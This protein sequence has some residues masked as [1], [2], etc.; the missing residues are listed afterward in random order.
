MLGAFTGVAV[1]I[2]ERRKRNVLHPLKPLGNNS[3]DH[4]TATDHLFQDADSM[5]MLSEAA[6]S[7][8]PACRAGRPTKVARPIDIN[9]QTADNLQGQMSAQ[10]RSPAVESTSTGRVAAGREVLS[11]REDLQKTT[12]G[13]FSG[14][15]KAVSIISL[16][17]GLWLGLGGRSIDS[18]ASITAVAEAVAP[19]ESAS[20]YKTVAI[21]DIQPA[22]YMVLADNPQTPGQAGGDFG[23]FDA[24]TWQVHRFLMDKPDGGWL[25]IGLARPMTW[26][27]SVERSDSGQVWLEFE[28]LGMAD[29]ATLQKTEPCPTDILGE[30]RLVTGTFEH[31]S[32][33]V[34]NLFITGAATPI[35]CTAGHFFWSEDRK[36]FVQA[37]DLRQGERLRLADGRLTHLEHSETIVEQ[38]PVY[39]LE[40][41]GEHVY[42]VGE[43][44]VLVHNTS[45]PHA[46]TPNRVIGKKEVLDKSGTIRANEA[47]LD[48][49]VGQTPKATWKSNYGELRKAM[50]ERRP[51]RDAT[52]KIKSPFLNAERYILKSRGWIQKTV[53]GDTFWMP[54]ST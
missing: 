5:T 22:G 10:R 11:G 49:V 44:A 54:P 20:K 3:D 40:V 53:G 47:K 30:G 12:N 8:G 33:D 34:L 9:N 1:L 43:L 36:D 7:V 21:R 50:R 35:G 23:E 37:A 25:K 38:L 41:D 24:K 16:L 17:L 27:E 19:H 13:R 6:S 15:L 28:E 2:D 52:P 29:W 18:G 48:V 14:T 4:A 42:F 26:I 45:A 31:S 39:N 51:I 46:G 32:G